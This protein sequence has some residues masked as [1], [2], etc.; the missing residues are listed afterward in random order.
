MLFQPFELN[1]NDYYSP[2]F[3]VDPDI[4][5]YIKIDF[6]TGFN[7]NYY[8]EDF[9]SGALRERIDCNNADALFSLCHVNIRSIPANLGNLE[10]YLQCLDFEFFIVGISETW[11]QEHNC[12]LYNLNGYNLVETHRTTKKRG[13]ALEYLSKNIFPM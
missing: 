7:C 8:M 2:L 10:A 12:D 11:L 1:T 3:D 6:H 4:N 5:F 9:F 13:V